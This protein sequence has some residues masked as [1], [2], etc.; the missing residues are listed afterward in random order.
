LSPAFCDKSERG[1]CGTGDAESA[2][3]TIVVTVT[4][5]FAGK[6]LSGL[7]VVAYETVQKVERTKRLKQFKRLSI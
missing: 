7:F 1:A 5:F 3:T 4:N 2:S 6:F